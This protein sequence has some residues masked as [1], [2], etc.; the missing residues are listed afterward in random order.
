MAVTSSETA[1]SPQEP[2]GFWHFV[3]FVATGSIAAVANLVSRYFL[4]RVMP[5]DWAVVIAYAIGM[6]IAF[7]LFQRLIFQNPATPLFRRSS[8]FIQVNLLGMFLTWLLSTLLAHQILPA[9]G[10][11]FR[12]HDIAHL[13]GV[14]APAFSSYFLH[15]GYTFR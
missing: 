7:S 8:R 2:G 4:D 5:F 14:A 11:T 10:W 9:V 12:P 6:V 3:R 1:A 13:L 15:K